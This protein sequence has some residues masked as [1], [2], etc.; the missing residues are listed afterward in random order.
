MAESNWTSCVRACRLRYC[1]FAWN[2]SLQVIIIY[3]KPETITYAHFTFQNLPCHQ[4]DSGDS[5]AKR[6][7]KELFQSFVF[8]AHVLWKYIGFTEKLWTVHNSTM[9]STSKSFHCHFFTFLQWWSR[10]TSFC[11]EVFFH[12]QF[13]NILLCPSEIYSKSGLKS[14]FLNKLNRLNPLNPFSFLPQHF[15]VILRLF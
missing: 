7:R 2:N 1:Y 11:F 10:F 12:L 15:H 13:N 9:Y 8:S 5:N 3:S 6:K 14:C 4:G